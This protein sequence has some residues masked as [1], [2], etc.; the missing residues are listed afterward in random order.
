MFVQITTLVNH[1]EKK[2]ISERTARA[3][4]HVGESVSDAVERFVVVGESIGEEHPELRYEMTETCLEARQA[5]TWLI[6]SQKVEGCRH[7]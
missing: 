6:S 2:R 1:K 5:G 4:A 7:A 3:L